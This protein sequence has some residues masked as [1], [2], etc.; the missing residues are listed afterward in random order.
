M[1]NVGRQPQRKASGP[2]EAFVLIDHHHITV[3]VG[4]LAL[5]DT[6]LL[7]VSG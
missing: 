4:S 1:R 3:Y 5:A 2:A 7:T 6:S